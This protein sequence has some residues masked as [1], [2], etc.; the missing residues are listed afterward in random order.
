[1]LD[2]GNDVI[3]DEMPVDDSILPAWKRDLAGHPTC[4]IRLSAP[5]AV[6]EERE[7]R[8]TRGQHLGNARGHFDI[9]T[10]EAYDLHLDAT[11][12]PPDELAVKI[13]AGCPF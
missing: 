3:L 13:T 6:V 8:R 12:A 10:D 11:T 1:M 5:L 2:S 9:G 7:A 4:W